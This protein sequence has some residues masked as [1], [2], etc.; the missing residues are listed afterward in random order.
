MA[1]TGFPK[2]LF[3]SEEEGHKYF[4]ADAH[5]KLDIIQK[6]I[7]ITKIV[8]NENFDIKWTNILKCEQPEETNY[9][10]QLFCKAAT[11]EKDNTPLIQKYLE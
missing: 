7:D 10:L 2:G 4:E 5:H 6:A 1:K 9:F 8:M 11:N 3:T